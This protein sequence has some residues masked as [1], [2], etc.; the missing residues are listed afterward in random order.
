MRAQRLH[1]KGGRMKKIFALIKNP[2]QGHAA[3]LI[4]ANRILI[5]G[6][7]AGAVCT[8]IVVLL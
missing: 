7:L 4:A 1:G 8:A 6:V 3:L 5:H 2:F